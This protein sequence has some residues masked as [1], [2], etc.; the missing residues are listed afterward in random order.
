MNAYELRYV[1]WANYKED[2]YTGDDEK[3]SDQV[4]I[5]RTLSRRFGLPL[6]SP[7]LS[8]K[9]PAKKIGARITVHIFVITESAKKTA[10]KINQKALLF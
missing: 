5:G 3:P 4:I 1:G 7:A 6:K 8:M 10:E 9:M 2:K